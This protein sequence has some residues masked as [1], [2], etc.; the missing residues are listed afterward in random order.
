MPPSGGSSRGSDDDVVDDDEAASLLLKPS[1]SAAAMPAPT[2]ACTCDESVRG[3]G[4]LTLVFTLLFAGW[5]PLENLLSTCECDATSGCCFLVPGLTLAS[6]LS[7]ADEGELGYY[8]LM[9]VY[10]AVVP[11]SFVAPW[12]MART[13]SRGSMFVASVPYTCFA[14]AL[15][16]KE[17]GVFARGELVYVAAVGVGLGCGVLWGSQGVLLKQFSQAYDIGRAVR[18]PP[19]EG[20]KQKEEQ[21]RGSLGLFN[22]IG[23]SAAPGGGLLALVLSSVMARLELG[24]LALYT[25]LFISLLLGN[26]LLFALPDAQ[27]LLAKRRR[28]QRAHRS[29]YAGSDSAESATEAASIL[30]IPRLLSSSRSL[31]F[32]QPCFMS[33]S[34]H[35]NANNVFD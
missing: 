12:V 5:V 13:G 20:G 7:H 23:Q 22:G 17:L 4:I 30:A 32:L 8:C 16:L 21:Q 35:C 26:L 29:V 9:T 11:G 2:G 3:L 15:V 14:G 25:S 24:K 10:M 34:E 28:Q 27:L 1:D 18:A 33:V 31:C 19:S 6:W